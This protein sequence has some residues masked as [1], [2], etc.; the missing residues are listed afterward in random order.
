MHGSEDKTQSKKMAL[1]ME[2]TCHSNSLTALGFSEKHS[3]LPRSEAFYLEILDHI[4]LASIFPAFPFQGIIMRE[5]IPRTMGN[6][7]TLQDDVPQLLFS[8]RMF[9]KSCKLGFV[10]P[11][12]LQFSFICCE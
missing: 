2:I 10:A 8:L 3:V 4:L 5:Y 1:N 12:M 6:D 9:I 7:L 11:G